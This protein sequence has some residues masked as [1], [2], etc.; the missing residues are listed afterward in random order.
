MRWYLEGLGMRQ[1]HFMSGVSHVAGKISNSLKTLS[2][3][4]RNSVV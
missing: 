3:I 1:R 2:I 4:L